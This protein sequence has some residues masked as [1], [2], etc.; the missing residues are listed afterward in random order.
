MGLFTRFRPRS[1]ADRTTADRTTADRTTADRTTADPESAG[2]ATG[3]GDAGESEAGHSPTVRAVFLGGRL[4]SGSGLRGLAAGAVTVLAAALVWATLVGPN[5]WARV[6]PAAFVRIP[7]ELLVLLALAVLL[8]AKARRVLAPVVGLLLGLLAI[9]KVLDMGFNATL[10]RPFDPIADWGYLGPA[11]SL[12]GDSIGRTGARVAAAGAALGAV[13]LVVLM[14]LA[15]RRL[16]GLAARHRTWSLRGLTG[17]TTVWVVCALLGA[18][19]APY[20]PIASTSGADLAYGQVRQV[21]AALADRKV[22]AAQIRHDRFRNVPGDRLLTGLRGKDVIVAIVESYGRVA[23]QGSAFAPRVD[24]ALDAGTGQLRRA[25]FTARSGFLTSPTFGG[26]SWLAHS[27]LQSGLW[28]DGQQRYNRLLASDRF[29]LSQAFNRAGWRTVDD[30]PSDDRNW[31]PGHDFYHFAKIYDR[32]NVGYHGPTFS[33]AAMPDQYVLAALQRRELDRAPRPPVMAE[34]DLVSSHTPWTPLPRLVPWDQVGDGSVFAGMAAG[35]PSVQ[36]VWRH[37]A[38]V[39]AA[40]GR[41]VIY[42]MTALTSFVAQAH[43]DNL[44]MVVLGDHQPSTIVSGQG[45]SRDVPVAVIAKD[46]S[47]MTSVA[48]WGWNPGLRPDP[49]APVWRMSAFRDKFLAAFSPAAVSP[50]AR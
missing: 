10:D 18:H 20:G 9:V 24:A 38:S 14:I 43:D 32:R 29:T 16:T 3:A 30:I 5:R 25:G 39:R 21:R 42:T 12:L 13:A 47:V 37:A 17:L 4:V 40:Y 46:P 22:F 34:I 33:Y 41:S 15:V 26:I 6:A 23:V 7:V 8:P 49:K 19:I 11:V 28:I 2:S 1:T 35:Q 44:V 48:G 45:A 31:P 50:A 36:Q 27:T